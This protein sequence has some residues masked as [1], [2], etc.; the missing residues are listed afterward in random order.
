MTGTWFRECPGYLVL[1]YCYQKCYNY[2]QQR[3]WMNKNLNAALSG[4]IAGKS[5]FLT[6]SGMLNFPYPEVARVKY[7]V[8]IFSLSQKSD[9]PVSKWYTVKW[10]TVHSKN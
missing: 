10:Y 2:I 6:T 8:R 9:S 1:F 7:K 5:K 4:G 3:Q